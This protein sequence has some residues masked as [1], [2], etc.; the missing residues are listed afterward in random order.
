M[1]QEEEKSAGLGLAKGT[2]LLLIPF[3]TS[4][5]YGSG[6]LVLPSHAGIGYSQEVD[7]DQGN[8]LSR[9]IS[10]EIIQVSGLVWERARGDRWPSFI[11]LDLDPRLGQ[12]AYDLTIVG[13]PEG[14]HISGGDS[15]GLRYGVQTLRQIIRQCGTVLPILQISDKPDYFIRSYSL[16]VTRGRVP[17]MEWLRHWADILALFKYNQLQL[18]IEHSFMFRGLNESWRGKS[19]LSPQDILDF[20]EYCHHLGIELVPSIST[21]GH[22]YTNLRTKSFRDLG[23]F[24]QDADRPYSFIERQEHHTLNVTHPQAFEFSANLIDSYAE[25]FRTRKFNIGAD[26]TFD[27]GRGSS[28]EQAQ[29]VGVADMYADYVIRLCDHVKER[30]GQPMFWGDIAVSMPQVLERLPKDCP[31]LNWLYDPQVGEEKI[32]LVAATG[33]RQVV[34]AAVHAWNNL[35]PAVDRAWENI[36]RLSSYGLQYGAMGA[37][38]TD[39]GDYGHINDPRMSLPGLA[40]ASQCF[41]NRAAADREKVDLALSALVYGD[42]TGT[43]MRALSQASHCISFGWDDMVR[44]WELDDGQGGVN[45]DVADFLGRQYPNIWL[46]GYPQNLEEARRG[47]LSH[48]SSHLEMALEYNRS[49]QAAEKDLRQVAGRQ[50]ESSIQAQVVALDGQCIFNRIGLI[51]GARLGLVQ[52]RS[53]SDEAWNVASDLETWYETYCDVWRT[54]SRESELSRISALVWHYADILR[55]D[56]LA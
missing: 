47:F 29:K 42:G 14:I 1:R 18:Y 45:T 24:P 13:K 2:S 53:S 30:G 34:C 22:H 32:R 8:L 12:Q 40:Y 54:V 35:I 21:F 44:Y 31:L 9:Q 51:L 20:D 5:T 56:S 10:D 17:T 55:A 28:R 16:D 25:L 49:L 7:M 37:M 33:A 27:L 26:E 39:W 4:L 50:G 3:P 11:E 41:W 52:V 6:E 46:S 38:V 19:P 43:Y 23:E 48:L 36:S 15:Q